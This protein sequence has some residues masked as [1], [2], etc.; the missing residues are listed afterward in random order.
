MIEANGALIASES[1]VVSHGSTAVEARRHVT[2]R[3][4][5]VTGRVN[6]ELAYEMKSVETSGTSIAPE[7]LLSLSSRI[8]SVALVRSTLN[9][10]VPPVYD[11][12][13]PALKHPTERSGLTCLS[14]SS[15]CCALALF[16]ATM[17][18]L[19]L[20]QS[21]CN[22]DAQDRTRPRVGLEAMVRRRSRADDDKA[23]RDASSLPPCAGPPVRAP[24]S[25]SAPSGGG[26]V[27]RVAAVARHLTFCTS[28]H[29]RGSWAKGAFAPA[30]EEGADGEE[31]LDMPPIVAGLRVLPRMDSRL[32]PRVC[33]RR[34]RGPS[35]LALA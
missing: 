35:S 16:A 7:S 3:R 25:G 6:F 21:R 26:D 20:I 32:Q 29:R 24:S 13:R 34:R 4:K 11:S 30:F 15:M 31:S 14:T 18:L 17:R 19:T 1:P 8:S 12:Q 27:R 5:F 9:D 23:A 33:R 28:E 10:L 2:R 22:I